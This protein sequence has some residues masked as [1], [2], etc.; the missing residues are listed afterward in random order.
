MGDSK[1]SYFY[2]DKILDDLK[3]IESHTKA[4]GYMDF[5]ANDLLI[6]SVCFKFVQVSESAKKIRRVRSRFIQMSPG[7]KLTD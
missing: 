5:T 2:I 3:F 7:I 1:A 4:I 6:Y